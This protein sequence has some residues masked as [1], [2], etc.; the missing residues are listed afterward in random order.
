MC[1]NFYCAA[2]TCKLLCRLGGVEG[3]GPPRLWIR[4]KVGG[5]FAYTRQSSAAQLFVANLHPGTTTQDIHVHV[6][7]SLKHF[8]PKVST[9]ERFHCVNVCMSGKLDI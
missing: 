2:Y 9:L 8:V 4:A 5:P 6:H 3:G 1:C 7:M